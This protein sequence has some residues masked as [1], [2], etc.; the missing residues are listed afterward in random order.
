MI[1]EKRTERW[2]LRFAQCRLCVATQA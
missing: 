1:A 2:T